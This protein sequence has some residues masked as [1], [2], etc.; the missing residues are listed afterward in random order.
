MLR[1]QVRQLREQ[2]GERVTAVKAL[3]EFQWEYLVRAHLERTTALVTIPPP[4]IGERD[5]DAL[6]EVL[7]GALAQPELDSMRTEMLRGV[8][9]WFWHGNIDLDFVFL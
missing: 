5:W 1:T 9:E 4:F 6:L 8:K 2:V 3:F 7:D